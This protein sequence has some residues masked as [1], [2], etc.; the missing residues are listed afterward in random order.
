MNAERFDRQVFS[1]VEKARTLTDP[2][3]ILRIAGKLEHISA[4]EAARE[5]ERLADEAEKKLGEVNE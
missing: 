5:C 4:W 3:A 1:L 2:H